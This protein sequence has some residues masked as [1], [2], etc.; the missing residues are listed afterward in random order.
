MF[1]FEVISGMVFTCTRTLSDGDSI[2]IFKKKKKKKNNNGSDFYCEPRV[3]SS[4]IM[5]LLL[6]PK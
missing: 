4:E 2:S 3:N 1:E 6:T 5:L